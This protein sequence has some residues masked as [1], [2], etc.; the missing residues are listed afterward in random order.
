MKQSAALVLTVVLLVGLSGCGGPE[1]QKA[2]YRLRAQ[3]Y[4]Q[5]GNF[6]KARVALRNVLKIDPKDVEAYFLYA[7]VEEKERNWRNAVAG[8]QQ[9]VELSPDHDRAL[10]KLAKYY[11]EARALEEAT[12]V[13]NRILAKNQGHV[14]AQALKIAVTAVSGRLNEAIGQAERLI[15][16]APDD[17]SEE[18]TSELQSPI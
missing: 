1:E 10:V 18:H 5:Q 15:A 4:F 6:S 13:T 16:A 7:Q 17:R 8:Y 12:Q 3:E 2:K 9:V 11:L 14:S